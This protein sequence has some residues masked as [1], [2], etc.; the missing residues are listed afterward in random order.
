MRKGVF[1]VKHNIKAV[2]FDY[3]GTLFFDA[4][5][6]E[7]AWRQTINELSNGK[8]DFDEMYK[9]Y[10]SARNYYFVKEAF[11]ILDIPADDEKIDY[12]VKRKETEYYQKY[13]VEH[14]RNELSPGTV[15]LL[16]YL[17]EKEVPINL[18]TASII[19]NL[20]FYFD[21]LK[22]GRWFDKDKV[23]YDDGTFVN[24][25]DMYIACAARVGQDIKDCLVIEDSPRSI[26]EAIEAGCH[27]IIVIKKKDTPEHKEIIQVVDD[28]SEI[29]YK[30]FE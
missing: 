1:H 24:K 26:E 10:K 22:I 6:N 27:N 30:I 18:C 4:D 16:N 13:C 5:I 29:D 15:Q 11:K 28:L 23:A 12:W 7:I 2:L 3:N 19:E 20:N 21:Y 8:I 17:K 9:Q 14:E 25:T